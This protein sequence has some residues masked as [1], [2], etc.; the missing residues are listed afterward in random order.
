VKGLKI[1]VPQAE[2]FIAAW[3]ALGANPA[4]MAFG[5]V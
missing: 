4:P 2:A 3:K 5:E 1:R